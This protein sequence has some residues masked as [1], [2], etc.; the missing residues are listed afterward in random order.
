MIGVRASS[1]EEDGGDHA[2]GNGRGTNANVRSD[3]QDK[4]LREQSF[5]EVPLCIDPAH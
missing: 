1:F 3:I 2:R 5:W 4:N